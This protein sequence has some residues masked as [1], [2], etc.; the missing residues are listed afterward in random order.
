MACFAEFASTV[1]IIFN[2]AVGLNFLPLAGDTFQ[3]I[4]KARTALSPA[5]IAASDQFCKEGEL[6]SLGSSFCRMA[7]L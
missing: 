4:L 1:E 2:S 5:N 6:I 3:V 7:W